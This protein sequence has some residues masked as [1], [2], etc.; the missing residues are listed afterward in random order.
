[1]TKAMI[2]N[3]PPKSI[4]TLD[5]SDL[6]IVDD[7]NCLGSWIGSGEKDFNIAHAWKACNSMIKN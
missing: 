4:K 2:F 5:D 1:M 6:E 3:I 7:F